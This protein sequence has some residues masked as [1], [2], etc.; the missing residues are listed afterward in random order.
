MEVSR[1]AHAGCLAFEFSSGQQR[2]I[3]NCGMPAAG[4]ENWRQV[5]R[6]TAAH[7]TVTFN[8]S[9]SCRFFDS[10]TFRRSFGVP[11]IDGPRTVTVSRYEQDHETVLR[12]VHDGYAARFGIIHERFVSLST[13][14]M[15]LEGEDV[16]LS[17]AGKELSQDAKD[18]FA[19]R[20]HLHPSIRASALADGHGAVLVLPNKD[21][22]NLDSH[23]DIVAVEESVYLAGPDGPRRTL[24]I[25][26]Y[27]RA[28]Q[29]DRVH[30]TFSLAPP[31]T[32]IVG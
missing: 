31:D 15:T 11:I 24:Q 10:A 27:G 28:H 29:V 21:V 1:D 23:E 25:V 12:A 16:F 8:D 3:V 22:W 9:S 5:A 30:W 26:I 4:R 6:A 20:F 7:S 18:S 14:G 13:D 2:I 17:A 19:V 32:T